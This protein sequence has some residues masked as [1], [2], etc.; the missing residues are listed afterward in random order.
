MK[1]L[2]IKQKVSAGDIVKVTAYNVNDLSYEVAGSV[3]QQ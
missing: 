1:T 2:E 3:P